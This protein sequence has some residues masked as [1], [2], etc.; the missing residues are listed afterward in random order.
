[1]GGGERVRG[2]K[3]NTINWALEHASWGVFSGEQAEGKKEEQ[4][5]CMQIVVKN[6]EE[7][8]K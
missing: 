6:K 8:G 1:M 3:N 5:E 2:E 4:L 7:G